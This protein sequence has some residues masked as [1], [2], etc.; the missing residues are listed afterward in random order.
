MTTDPSL[1]YQRILLFSATLPLLF[2]SATPTAAG[3]QPTAIWTLDAN[4]IDGTAVK[5]GGTNGHHGQ[6]RRA[7]L[8]SGRLGEALAFDTSGDGVTIENLQLAGHQLSV[9]L[10]LRRDASGVQ[11]LVYFNGLHQV[12]FSGDTIFVHTGRAGRA[13]PNMPLAPVDIPHGKWTHLAVTWDTAAPSEQVKVYLDGAL[14][15]QGTLDNARGKVLK[16][17]TLHLGHSGQDGKNSQTFLGAIDDVALFDVALSAEAIEAAYRKTL[18]A[19]GTTVPPTTPREIVSQAAKPPPLYFPRA[20]YTGR[21]KLL[22]IGSELISRMLQSESIAAADLPRR[23]GLWQDRGLDGLVFTITSLDRG[24]PQRYWNMCGQWWAVI[25][26]TYEE[27]LPDIRAFQAVTDWGRLTDNFLWSSYAV[28]KDGERLR[29]QD[30]FRDEDWAVILD[31]TRL[32]ARVARECGFVGVLFDAEQYDGHHAEGAWHIPFNYANYAEGGYAAEGRD[33]PRPFKEVAAQLRKRGRQYA[34]ALCEEFPGL[35]ILMIPGLYEWSAHERNV[36]LE[37]R[38]YSLYPAF[39]DGVLDG[40]DAKATLIGGSEFTY[41]RTRYADIGH[42]R[43]RFD[44]AIDAQA[45]VSDDLKPKMSF[46]AGIWVDTGRT[47]SDTDV[48]QNAR[49]PA[50]HARAVRNAFRASDEYVWIYGE[51]S[52]FLEDNPTALMRAYFRANDAARDLEIEREELE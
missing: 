15:Y 51:Q 5:D 3:P 48:A 9:M 19:A 37:D 17:S 27:L 35:K 26:R 40:M 14:R 47:W 4:T 18:T 49:D 20:P 2:A 42:E 44:E 22:R 28:W 23:V 21:K 52:K 41:D 38:H 7:T 1:S 50:A 30:W 46:A 24:D 25:P 29:C 10:W 16:V 11:R 8:I 13:D 43:R 6:I 31:N 45:D 32:L 39:I 12:G 34:E 33:T 36:P